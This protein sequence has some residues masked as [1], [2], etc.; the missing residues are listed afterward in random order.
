MTPSYMAEQLL[1][2][3]LERI[4][5]PTLYIAGFK[6]QSGRELA[7]ERKRN[8]GIFLWTEQVYGEVPAQFSGGCV[9]YAPLKPRNSNLNGKNAPRLKLGNSV[10]YWRLQLEFLSAFLDWYCKQ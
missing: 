6:T 2:Q 9:V 5:S 3:R 1:A 10:S 4:A 8:T 7:L